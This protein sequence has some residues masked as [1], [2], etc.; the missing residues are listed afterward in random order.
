MLIGVAVTIGVMI[1]VLSK[2]LGPYRPYANKLKSY[3]CGFDGV[4]GIDKRFSVKFYL[5][6][7]LFIIFDIEIAFLIPWATH[8]RSMS[9]ADF[10]VGMFFILL[11]AVILVYEWRS[12][13]LEW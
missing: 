10:Y 12:G 11:L 9:D 3:E 13:A 6:G 5:V 8:V 1:L 7:M 4:G 2:L